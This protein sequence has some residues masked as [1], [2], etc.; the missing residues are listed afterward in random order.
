MSILLAKMNAHLRK[1]VKETNIKIDPLR[2]IG[3]NLCKINKHFM[4]F[5][6]KTNLNRVDCFTHD[7]YFYHENLSYFF[8]RYPNTHLGNMLLVDNM[9]YKTCLNL[10][11]NAIF[12]ESYEYV[13]KED[14]YLIKTIFMCLEFLHNSRLIVPTFVELYPFNAIRS[15]EEDDVKFEMFKK[16]TIMLHQFV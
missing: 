2:I 10:P 4:Q 12:V 8:P 3:Q 9:P 11:F 14:N 7:K 1:I 5:P 15:L 6:F 13:P 16:C